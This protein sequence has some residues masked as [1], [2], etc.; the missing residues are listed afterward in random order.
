MEP[1]PTR[2][3][4]EAHLLGSPIHL[5][6]AP[7]KAYTS[8][9]IDDDVGGEPPDTKIL[10]GEVRGRLQPLVMPSQRSLAMRHEGDLAHTSGWEGWESQFKRWWQLGEEVGGEDKHHHDEQQA[11]SSGQPA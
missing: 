4:I 10:A 8:A 5:I 11:A 1:Y 6:D 2:E 3:H 9:G 7:H